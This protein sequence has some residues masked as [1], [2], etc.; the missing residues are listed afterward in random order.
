[1]CAKR[2][3][4]GT[5]NHRRVYFDPERRSTHLH[6]IGGSGQGKS[7]FLE[8]LIR[9]DIVA[10][11]GL[12]LIDPHGELCDDIIKF[13]AD[14]GADKFRRIHLVDPSN[15]DWRFSFNPLAVRPGEK[16]RDRVDNVIE[17]LA[18][19]WGGEDSHATPA[20]RI[21]LRAVLAALIY[22]H[23]TLAESFQLTGLDDPDGR[24]AY[25]VSNI[26]D[27][28]TRELWR[29]F[30][31]MK[32]RAPREFI[33]EFGGI[34]RRLLELLDD[35]EL[36]EMFGTPSSAIDFR[37]CM[38]EDEIVLVN[39]SA[40]GIGADRA[41]ALGALI[42]RELFY[43][44][45]QRDTT[46][47]K[48]HPF[49]LYIDECG[50]YLTADV[51]DLLAQTRKYGLH[52]ILAHQWLE[53][54]REQSP[55]IYAAVMAIQN[56]VVFG[57]LS[58]ADATLMA[59]ELF[60]TEYD[61]QIPVEALTKETVVGYAR[62]WLNQW[63]ESESSSETESEASSESWSE[64]ESVG[65]SEGASHG[66]SESSGDGTSSSNTYDK[67]GYPVGV[68]QGSSSSAGE[69][70]SSGTSWS[71]SRSAGSSTSSGRTTTSASTHARGSS[72]GQSETLMPILEN[73]V[74]AVHG[75]ENVRHMAVARLRSIPK[76]NAVVKGPGVPSFDI[77]TFHVQE[78]I[79]P[80]SVVASFKKRIMEAS[81]YVLPAGL[82][83]KTLETRELELVRIAGEY[84]LPPPQNEEDEESAFLG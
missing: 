51:A 72:R 54:L 37:R 22:S 81:P 39:L 52:A 65:M 50:E 44:A 18:Q 79:V 21:T 11:H 34:R 60:R 82:A 53:Q 13:C 47:A 41:R 57:G 19:V 20:I 30:D 29:G 4:I 63:S 5:S 3:P 46:H 12:C 62:T 74:G 84:R 38:D 33:T 26:K 23:Q 70:T 43:V 36:T 55:G 16:P 40:R 71:M 77:A 31:I 32:K 56:K 14:I 15:P 75:L 28:N 17:A 48:A 64:S 66:S 67:D 78:P 9:K 25:M 6:V 59:D 35:P 49:Y 80:D 68:V 83:A 42:V 69:S 10:G 73:R 24:L 76:Q 27:P 1:M 61:L 8:H 58:D 2:I 7:K 45:K